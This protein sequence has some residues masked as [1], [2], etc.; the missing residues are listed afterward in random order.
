MDT[1]ELTSGPVPTSSDAPSVAAS[2]RRRLLGDLLIREGLVSRQQ[3]DE[4]LRAQ[5]AAEEP[6]PIGEILVEGRVITR[7]QL[8]FVLE[9][10][11]KKYRLGDILVETNAITEAQLEA[12]LDHQKRTG[13][14]LG[15]A[16]LELK[17]LS[18]RQMKE[19]LC[20]QVRATFVDLDVTVI[21]RR[22]SELVPRDYAEQRRVLPVSRSADRLTVAM[23][24]PA[25][26]EVVE[27]LERA[28]G[29]RIDVVTSTHAAFERAFRLYDESPAA[30]PP[31]SAG[32]Q[33]AAALAALQ[34]ECDT[35]RRQRDE[36]VQGLRQL[37]QRHAA[38]LGA[39]RE[40]E[41]REAETTRR[42]T[43]LQAAHAELSEANAAATRA[44]HEQRRQHE[45]LL[46]Q[47]GQKREDDFDAVLRQLGPPA[48]RRPPPRP[49]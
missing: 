23:E 28:T 35:L 40:L 34:A 9:K 43:E 10:Y 24:D 33:D 36:A 47:G 12:A 45:A 19:A 8:D 13:L 26:V 3:L 30:D 48:R 17:L 20:K 46:R 32:A 37:E 25:D 11:H 7:S 5:A 42:L 15:A 14:K 41:A 29:C 16:L 44:L 2:P 18:E 1:A 39:I 4:A 22:L 6:R 49:R 31:P 27:E 38:A 21:E